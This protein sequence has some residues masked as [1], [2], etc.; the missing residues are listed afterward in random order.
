MLT[1]IPHSFSPAVKE[2]PYY[3]LELLAATAANPILSLTPFQL[4]IEWTI[5]HR[6]ARIAEDEK[7]IVAATIT[8]EDQAV[9]AQEIKSTWP[10]LARRGY[11]DRQ[12]TQCFLAG[13]EALLAAAFWAYR[14]NILYYNTLVKAIGPPPANMV[15]LN[16]TSCLTTGITGLNVT[17]FS[18]RRT[19]V[20]AAKGA[21]AELQ[22]LLQR[23][24]QGGISVRTTH[25]TS[26]SN[27]TTDI[28]NIIVYLPFVLSE[29][30]YLNVHVA[31]REEIGLDLAP[32]QS[33]TVNVKLVKLDPPRPPALMAN[34]DVL[35]T[36]AL[37][38]IRIEYDGK[39]APLFDGSDSNVSVLAAAAARLVAKIGAHFGRAALNDIPFAG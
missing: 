29:G 27:R 13:G 30:D 23:L 16:S 4:L 20:L 38:Q 39:S 35:C 26:N 22:P 1:G 24:A 6:T 10:D 11:T 15:G 18:S 19:R 5:Y 31:A 37:H 9:L 8:D 14:G 2:P 17:S 12:L 21:E 25:Y 32:G 7:S 33:T 34:L 36:L 3:I 28:K